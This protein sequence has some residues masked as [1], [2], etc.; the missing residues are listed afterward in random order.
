VWEDPAVLEEAAAIVRFARDR[1]LAREA[2][3][4]TRSAAS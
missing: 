1:R 2:A 3:A 4:Q